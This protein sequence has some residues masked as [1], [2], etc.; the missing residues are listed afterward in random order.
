MADLTVWVTAAEPALGWERGAFLRTYRRNRGEAIELGLEASPIAQNVR[1]LIDSKQ[2]WE[3]TAKDLLELIMSEKSEAEQ[4]ARAMPQTPQVIRNHLK[5]LAPALRAIGIDVIFG[6]RKAR[7]GQRLITIEKVSEH[8]VT[9][10]TPVT[11]AS[12]HSAQDENKPTQSPRGDGGDTGD[13]PT[14]EL[15][16]QGFPPTIKGLGNMRHD[17]LGRCARCQE[18]TCFSY[19][20]TRLCSTH[21]RSEVQARQ[22][23]G[24]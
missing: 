10:V 21:A 4:R 14:H 19:G 23:G 20:G 2:R 9:I 5:R 1:A 3:G 22:D 16:R 6:Q 7:T 11:Q 17:G 12:A 13:K 18:L 8:A 15:A 24:Q